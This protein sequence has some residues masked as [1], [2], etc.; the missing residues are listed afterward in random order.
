MGYRLRRPSDIR[1]IERPAEGTPLKRLESDY[2]TAGPKRRP[3]Q[4]FAFDPM[5]GRSSENRISVDVTNEPL[6]H[7]PRGR[8][9]EVVDY[10]AVHGVFYA[11]VNLDNPDILMTGGL[12]PDESDPR[13]HQ[14]MVYAVAMKVFENF[15]R[16]LGRQ[17]RLLHKGR[18][19][20]LRVLP[21]AFN[22]S[23]AFYDPK[24]LSL[25]F[26]YFTADLDSPG[27]NIPG[28]VVFTSLSHDI[29]A[30][31][32][33]HAVVDRLRPYFKWATNRDVYAFHEAIAD[34]V[35]IF[36]HFTFPDILQ[37]AIREGRTDLRREDPLIEL[38]RQ[39]GHAT[40]GG[41]ALRTATEPDDKPD[42]TL[43]ESTFEPHE[44]GS[45]LVRAVFD[46]FFNTYQAR[47]ADLVRIATG[48]TGVLSEGEPPTDLVRRVA[49]EAADTAQ[50]MLTMCIRAFEYLPPCDLRLGDYLRA[51]VTADYTLRP[52]DQY[53]MRAN[54]IEAFRA[55][56][57]Y[58]DDVVSLAEES[59]V[60]EEA[61]RELGPLH[62][63]VVEERLAQEA[64]SYAEV[65]QSKA[66]S[67]RKMSPEYQ[68]D[69]EKRL[70]QEHQAEQ[71]VSLHEYAE[72]Y[73]SEL[74][75]HPD[76]TIAVHGFHTMFRVGDDGQLRTELVAQFTQKADDLDPDLGG[77][78]TIGGTTVIFSAEGTPRYIIS[79]PLPS[80][81]WDNDDVRERANVRVERIRE[82]VA[83]CDLRDSLYAWS[84]SIDGVSRMERRF[85][86]ALVHQSI[87]RKGS[88]GR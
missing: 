9:I 14:Q 41:D 44:R 17:V 39:F 46:A 4:I 42:P 69:R 81:S 49:A 50:L 13:F 58:P 61:G 12:D 21:H 33:T 54:L 34:L 82:F 68:D 52:E 72:Q 87:R 57:I 43:Y 8:L 88:D 63:E 6:T 45:I 18:Y 35:A 83:D 85:D 1:R 36:Q 40:G 59:L 15:E 11:P 10:D 64:Q 19:R 27:A 66:A 86:F 84:Q 5:L 70:V 73:R 48:G 71:A 29:V 32:T 20:P 31:E 56:G 75:L 62:A 55:R 16:A 74:H 80:D 24:T 60:W 77:L 23:N 78:P 47:I 38:A 22:G 53:H 3:L 28:Q 26:G 37:R 76:L 79:K 30:H 7:G 2:V 67:V 51:L 25:N 65:S